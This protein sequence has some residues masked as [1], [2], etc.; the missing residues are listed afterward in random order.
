[1]DFWWISDGFGIHLASF[2]WLVW[3]RS[4]IILKL[5][6]LCNCALR[7]HGGMFLKFWWHLLILRYF[8]DFLIIRTLVFAAFW[9]WFWDAFWIVFGKIYGAF[10][11]Q[12]VA[13]MSSQI[14][15]KVGIERSSF[16]GCPAPRKYPWLEPGGI[17]PLRPGKGGGK[18]P[19]MGVRC[20]EERKKRRKEEGK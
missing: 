5:A 13:T 8:H 15:T 7:Q 12:N 16:R 2:L 17:P 19:P 20:L 18:P 1:M 11:C 4:S 9:Y 10:G 14:D 3:D 6:D